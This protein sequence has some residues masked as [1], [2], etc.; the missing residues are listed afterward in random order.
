MRD[1]VYHLTSVFDPA[2]LAREE[3]GLVREYLAQLND[4]LAERS[5]KPLSFDDAWFQVSGRQL[6]CYALLRICG[7]CPCAPRPSTLCISR[8]PIHAVYAQPHVQPQIPD[9]ECILEVL[10]FLMPIKF[11]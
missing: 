11:K 3:E 2:L 5:L 1:V 7:V 10:L 4:K 9:F 6:L 8:R